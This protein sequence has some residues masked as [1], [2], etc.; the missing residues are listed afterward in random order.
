LHPVPTGECG[1][2]HQT[3]A[4]DP[5]KLLRHLI[6]VRDGKCGFPACSRAAKESDLEHAIPHLQGGQTC[7]CNCWTCSRSC[8]QLK[9]SNGWTVRLARPG[10]K[11]WQTPAGRLYTQQPW[12]YPS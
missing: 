4:H 10:W 9:Q 11:Q 12:C 5:G 6:Q 7:G 1:H 8:H 3:T 2:E